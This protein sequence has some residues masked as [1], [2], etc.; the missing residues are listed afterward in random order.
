M[1]NVSTDYV[2]S[3]KNYM[4]YIESELLNPQSFYG[5]TKASGEQAIY[6]K[7]GKAIIVRTS[8]L[9]SEFGHNFVKTML[10][11]GKD[12]K[13]LSVV[14][15]QIGTPTYAA[16]LADAILQ[17]IFKKEAFDGIQIFHYSNE[18]ICSWYDFASE[19]MELND[20]SCH[21]KPIESKDY[22]TP[23]P[24]PFY[25]VLNKSKIKE[26][27]NI[28]IPHWKDGLKRCLKRIND[29]S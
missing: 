11:L 9:Y 23:A 12:K 13:E 21:V 18:G 14:C 3:G 28:E 22:P 16:D 19:I 6:E 10:R 27:L 7:A 20:L 4:P 26:E 29:I 1:I 15:D 5:H 24:R 25:S 17:L 2:F 8:W